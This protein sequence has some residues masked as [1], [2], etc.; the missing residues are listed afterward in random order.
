MSKRAAL[1]VRMRWLSKAGQAGVTMVHPFGVLGL[2]LLK[3]TA[4]YQTYKALS[5]YGWPRV[6]RRLMEQN[7]VLTPKA[8]QPVVADAVKSALRSPTTA[9]RG[10][11]TPEVRRFVDRLSGIRPLAMPG[12]LRSLVE[13][14]ESLLK[15][16]GKCKT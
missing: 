13:L 16:F 4:A 2:L 12:A 10:L 1:D 14:A 9:Y 11:Q 3:K 7:R 6:Y 15:P 5:A 8:A